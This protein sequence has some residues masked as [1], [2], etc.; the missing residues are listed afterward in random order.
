MKIVVLAGGLSSERDVS[1]VS[2]RGICQA[3]R[4]RGH[5]AVLLDVFLGYQGTPDFARLFSPDLKEGQSDGDLETCQLA[6]EMAIQSINPDIEAVRAMR[7]DGNGLFGPHVVEICRRADIVYLGLH[8]AEGE[9]G[10]VQAAF[11]VLGIKYTGSGYL[12]SALA[13]DKGMAKKLFYYAGIPTPR[14]F[15]VTK[16][17]ADGEN[18]VGYPCVVKPCC[19]GS[20]VG[21]SI[22][23]NEEEYRSALETGFHYEEELLVEECIR[24]REFSV[25]VIDGKSLPVIEIIPKEGFYDYE[26]KYQPGMAA[27]VCPAELTKELA[28]RMQQYAIEVFKELK[29]EVY[30][31]ID[32]LLDKD[33]NM[34]CLEANTLPG[35]TA[36][37]LLPQE[38]KEAGVDYGELCEQI[39]GLSM[40]K[41]GKR[42][43]IK[44]AL[45]SGANGSVLSGKA[46]PE[47][48][49]ASD[50]VPV[51]TSPMQGMTLTKIAKACG[52]T[53]YGPERLKETEV[54]MITTDSRQVEQNCLFV[55][56]QGERVDGNI[57]VEAAY[58]DGAVCCMSEKEPENSDMPYIVVDSCYQAL[59]DMAELYRGMI[60]ATV[61]GITGSVGKTTTKEM[62]ASVL[63]ERFRVLKTKG[64]FNNEVGVPLT[65]FRLRREHEVAVVEMGISD[66]GEMTR[67]SKM[68]R[69]H[70][71]IIT[72]VGECHLESLGDRNGVL[73]AKTE[74]FR[75]MDSCGTAYLNGD[76]DKLST[77]AFRDG[78]VIAAYGEGEVAGFVERDEADQRQLRYFSM[79]PIAD[80]GKA[81]INRCRDI[82][83]ENIINL[84]LK[85]TRFTVVAGNRSFNVQ[86]PVPGEHMVRNAL[87]AVSVALDMGM[88][89]EEIQRGIAKFRPVGGHGSMVETDSFTILDDCYN[90]NP[91]SMEAGINVL[92]D[93]LGRRV[94]II[95]DMFE[96]GENERELHRRIGECAAAAGLDKLICIGRLAEEAYRGAGAMGDKAC[97]FATKEEAMAELPSILHKGDT[98]LVKASHGMCFE[99]IVAQLKEM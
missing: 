74:I 46:S 16:A 68:V 96:L 97:Y 78:K 35:M 54:A 64:N 7:Q 58:R 29:L 51:W 86:V 42:A 38:A 80:T 19:G 3:L 66:F 41:Y 85:G 49:S 22:A 83:A 93:A 62:V 67:L 6:G 88:A 27:D 57:F 77:V 61:I 89:P 2:G 12:G 9:N 39:I 65:L 52:G 72:N 47:R 33:N 30:A 21:V 32:F 76:D 73:K 18:E 92:K 5:Q 79:S 26:T 81:S 55:A 36:T 25:G 82:Y 23:E 71:C 63:S 94:A 20:S 91:A 69:P 50:M 56:I 4:E 90:A 84:G 31:R 10:K 75:Y 43:A 13:M 8:G 34:Y 14:G 15:S 40:R 70:A 44:G 60:D 24:G 37:S 17:T 98:I 28:G 99:K 87:A 11:D 53:Y 1:L 45:G 48:Y 95:G 59:K